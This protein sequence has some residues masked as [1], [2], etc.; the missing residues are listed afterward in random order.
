MTFNGLTNQQ[1]ENSRKKYGSNRSEEK[2]KPSNLWIKLKERFG[3]INIKIYLAI[4]LFYCAA[5]L[6][7]VVFAD[8]KE[9]LP[10]LPTVLITAGAMLAAM[11]INCLIELFYENKAAKQRKISD[12]CICRV[13]RCGNTIEEIPAGDIV[14]G[15]YVLVEE[16]DVVPAEGI[17]VYGDAAADNGDGSK[18]IRNP[19]GDEEELPSR[20]LARG[21]VI[22]SG[23][24]VIKITKT[25]AG[26]PENTEPVSRGLTAAS[27]CSAVFIAAYCVYSVFTSDNGIFAA[28]LT[29]AAASSVLFVTV[30]ERIN[31]PLGFFTETSRED[32]NCDG[33]HSA[34]IKDPANMVFIDKSAFVTDG[35]PVV[36]GFLDGSGKS[37]S[38]CYE[39]P[40]PLGTILAKAIAENTSVL[41]NRGKI[42]GADPLECAEAEYISERFKST[43]DLEIKSEN[44]NG[45]DKDFGYKKLYKDFPDKL[46]PKCS[47]YYDAA[48]TAKPFSDGVAITAMAD[49]IIFQGS[50]VIAYAAED[51][52]GN[53]IFIGLLTV[54]E[55]LRKDSAA[56]F[57]AMTSKG[58]RAI[59]LTGEAELTSVSMPVKAVTGAGINEVISF[60]KLAE[61]N[62]DD[63]R[64][65]L[66]AIKV[67]TGSVNK[68]L[69]LALAK[70]GKYT[71]GITALTRDDTEAS[72][73]A[74]VIYASSLSCRAAKNNADVILSDGLT[75]LA[76]YNTY[77]R[78]IKGAAIGYTAYHT[79]LMLLTAA[80]VFFGINTAALTTVLTGAGCI[81]FGRPRHSE[82]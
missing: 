37:F 18:L 64:R 44:I 16:G 63:A 9:L 17:V 14:K 32:M 51:F 10:G 73:E 46:I 81:F 20:T 54:H 69:L 27:I 77:S 41:L 53:Y 3:R 80:A 66:P 15:D 22:T 78:K 70:G 42:Y 49:E 26:E 39:I 7:G 75:S 25:G 59:L 62:E 23:Y 12:D 60:E 6:F 40:Y 21:A 67:I 8:N 74:D 45:T 76:K 4:L 71:V 33:V 19:N 31:R 28:V 72:A 58:T 13:Y 29:A 68:E 82:K 38:K 11:I 24:A 50:S 65:M 56:M 5:A 34:K 55:K 1:A 79:A 2:I 43:L 57:R 36:T 61:M 35:K 48:G 52:D 30:S 47:Y